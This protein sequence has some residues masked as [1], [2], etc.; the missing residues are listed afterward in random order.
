MELDDEQKNVYDVVKFLVET[1]RGD[2]L[3][4]AEANQ[5]LTAYDATGRDSTKLQSLI[6]GDVSGQGNIDVDPGDVALAQG[7][8]ISSTPFVPT[9]ET[10]LTTTQAALKAMEERK[11][12]EAAASA[13]TGQFAMGGIVE[14]TGGMDM[15]MTGQG[16]ETFLNPERSKATLRRNLAKTAPRPTMQTGIM[17]MAR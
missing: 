13:N 5:I 4:N 8:A 10:G 12:A 6:A 7:Q 16:L 3:T 1:R 11:A 9:G 17:P 14:L 15:S 2:Q